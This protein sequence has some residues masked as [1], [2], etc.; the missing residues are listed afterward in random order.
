LNADVISPAVSY[1][2]AAQPTPEMLVETW[3][4]D[5]QALIQYVLSEAGEG[6][7]AGASGLFENRSRL[8]PWAQAL[9]ALTFDNLAPGDERK[10]VLYADLEAGAV[11]SATGAHWENR[12]A[13][14]QNMST[15]LQT[16]AVVLYSFANQDPA[17]PLV[18][19]A[20]R[21]LM[22]HR[23]SSGAWA[24][25]YESAWALMAA[26]EVM[27]GTGELGGEFEFYAD[28]NDIPLVVGEAVGISQLTPVKASIPISEL[29]QSE[30][31][32]LMLTRG[33]G[34]G[35]LYYNAHLNVQRPVEE[36]APLDGGITIRRSY[37][38]GGEVCK[39]G[40][41]PAIEQAGVG[42]LV[43]GRLTL[44]VPETVYYLMVEDHI[45]AGAEILDL[46][47]DTTQTD[48][49]GEESLF[50]QAWGWWEF[51]TPRIF[52]DRIT[53][54]ANQLPPGT[55]ELV[56]HMVTTQPGEYRV[57]PARAFQLYFPEVQGNGAG[58]IFKINE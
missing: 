4:L 36:I 26:A 58:T 46:R 25:T 12:E 41:C 32:S 40:D 31:N 37:F 50:G 29:Y 38:P 6:D 7:L 45:P 44:T 16:T 8:N 17:S 28:I 47:L 35:R 19:E 10:Q 39:E 55:Y 23:D 33:D 22:A 43:T 34:G 56:Y 3:Q 21:Y 1:L 27:Q 18:A 24:S 49:L 2:I 14:W 15:T 54:A 5:R 9:L 42:Q 20:L 13:S 51:G 30:P 48:Q 53:W 52:D 57:L 11:R